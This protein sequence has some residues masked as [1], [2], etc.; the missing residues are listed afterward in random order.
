MFFSRRKELSRV[1]KK[2]M[3]FS[4]KSHCFLRNVTD[5]ILMNSDDLMGSSQGT[6]VTAIYYRS[7][8]VQHDINRIFHKRTKSALYIYSFLQPNGALQ[9]VNWIN[10]LVVTLL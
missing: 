7:K 5:L 8:W 6:I 4:E 3:S 9:N 2:Q 10:L 1:G